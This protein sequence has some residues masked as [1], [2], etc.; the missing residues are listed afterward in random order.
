[1]FF[2]TIGHSSL[3]S[4][5]HGLGSPWWLIIRRFE[6]SGKTYSKT[7]FEP[8]IRGSVRRASGLALARDSLVEGVACKMATLRQ[9]T[10][11]GPFQGAIVKSCL[12]STNLRMPFQVVIAGRE[13]PI[14]LPGKRSQT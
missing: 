10:T 11:S 12:A 7:N 8:A 9:Q 14:K 2:L 13:A 4:A 5:P 1:V 3:V 6:L